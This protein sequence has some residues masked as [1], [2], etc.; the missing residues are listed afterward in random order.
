[1]YAGGEGISSF[2]HNDTLF[3]LIPR[4]IRLYDT[5]ASENVQ[6]SVIILLSGN[7]ANCGS[8]GLGLNQEAPAHSR[9][10][11]Y[12][13]VFKKFAGKKI[14]VNNFILGAAILRGFSTHVLIV[15]L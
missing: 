10:I 4:D 9:Y 2:L 13:K 12:E 8:R 7:F 6:L 5:T 1:M 11:K 14:K 3:P 15:T